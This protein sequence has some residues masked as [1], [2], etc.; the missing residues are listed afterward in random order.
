M[1]DTDLTPAP[2]AAGG[3]GPD[4]AIGLHATG[5]VKRFPAEKGFLGRV[6][7]HVHA[8]DGVDLHVMPGETLGIVGESGSGKSTVGRLVARLLTPDEGTITLDGRDISRLRGRALKDLRAEMQF[9]FQ[10]PYS[11]LDPTRTV[12]HAVA[13]PLLVHGRVSRGGMAAAAGALLERVGLDPGMVTRRPAELSGGQRQRVCIARSLALE[14]RILVADEPTSAL[15]L[16][17]Q[18]EIL[19]LLLDIQRTDGLSIIL[20]SHDFAAIRHL[21]HRI[22]VM[23]LG[24]VVEEGDAEQVASDPVHPYTRALLSAVPVPDP[25]VQRQRNRIV[26]QGELPNPADPPAGCNFAS[27]CPDVVARCAT[28]DPP[29]VAQDD[30]R[31]VA[32][33]HHRG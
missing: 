20:I 7:S 1:T 24:R 3:D 25:D 18:S 23:Y 9:V 4:P 22:A 6:R 26:L 11:A 14:P 32:C 30:G 17:T 19:N 27:R 33:V 12:G 31:R 29:L 2:A 16:S 13:E 10:D 21:A 15:D 28:I 5:L 8:V